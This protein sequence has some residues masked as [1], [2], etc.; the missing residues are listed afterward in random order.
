[1]LHPKPLLTLIAVLVV[2]FTATFAQKTTITG[3]IENI[4]F[5]Q[6]DLQLLYKDDGVSFGNA[7]IKPDGTFKLTAN[8]PQTDLY[9]LVFEDGQHFMLCLSPNEN[10]ELTLDCENLPMIISVKGSP[11]V[12][13]CKTASEMVKHREKLL[14]SINRALQTDKDLQFY[15]EFQ[16]Q[17]KP[18]FDANTDANEYCL[19]TAKTTDSLQ[20]FVKN[21]LVKGKVDSK[22]VDAFIYTGSNLLKDIFTN[23]SKYI[24][25]MQSMG[26][27]NDFKTNRNNKFKSFYESSV[28][29]YLEFLEQR[30][31]TMKTNFSGFVDQIQN[32]LLLRDSLQINDLADKKKEKELLTARIIEL[33]NVIANAKEIERSLF[34]VTQAADGFGKYTQQ[35]AQRNAST[36]VQ[37]YQKYFDTEYEKR[38]TNVINYLLAN[39]NDLAVL[40]FVDMFPKDQHQALHSEIIKALYEKYP[41][42]PMVAERY[43]LVSSPTTSTSVG[44]MAP[45]LAF[46]NPEGKVLKLS[47]LRGKVVLLDFWASWCGPCRKENPNVVQTYKKYH[48]QGFEV[49]SVSLDR[50]KA[51]WLKAIEADGLVWSNHVSDLGFWQSQA[52]KIYGVSSIPATFLIDKEG[53]IIAKNLRGAALE[54][55]LKGLFE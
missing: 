7:K 26:L 50:D 27:L 53:K 29:K 52:A 23:Y 33:S 25:Y 48:D 32:Y 49:Y 45:D 46:E 22:E 21:K 36:M 18:Y 11:S 54:N 41:K 40:L 17:F 42:Q 3:T 24:S 55:A 30:D 28:D 47:D 13:F 1:M 37:Q 4:C 15:S 43:K 34:S 19:A 12:A 5:E 20:Q 35:E 16:S 6:V 10:V 14:D 39:K 9:K 44:A 51:S 31:A 38:T 8:I 2:S